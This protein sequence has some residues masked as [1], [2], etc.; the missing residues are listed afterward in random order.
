MILEIPN[1]ISSEK[2]LWIREAVKPFLSKT[3]A[4]EQNRDGN[5][6]SITYNS[7]LKE[8]DNFLSNVFSNIQATVLKQRFNIPGRCE[9]GD[10]GYEYHLYNPGDICHYHADGEFHDGAQTTLLRYASVTLHLNTVEE[11]G[12]LIFPV[13]D[14][15]I[16]TE[17]GKI[18]V[19]PPYGMYSHYTSPS[20]YPREVIVTWFV[21]QNFVVSRK[22]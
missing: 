6:V 16:K 8:V 11:G 5:T 20:I 17:E 3:K 1:A 10:S 18:V 14:K 22:Y 12:E 9:S 15:K 7:E 21:Y 4:H 19:F 2:C 13:Q